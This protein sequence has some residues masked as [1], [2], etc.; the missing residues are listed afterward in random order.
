MQGDVK[1][2]L[3]KLAIISISLSIILSKYFQNSLFKFFNEDIKVALCT[4]GKKE[5]LYA[6][7]FIEYYI[8]LGIDHIFIYD[9]NKNNTERISDCIK[10]KYKKKVTV[11]ENIQNYIKKQ[12]DAFTNCYIN[13][14]K[15]FDWFLMVDMDEYLYIVNNTLKR[16]LNSND[17]IKCDFIKF[18]SVIP[19]D[20]NLTNYDNRSLFERFK[21]PYLKQLDVKTIIKGNISKL[22][23]SIH[24]PYSSPERNITC[25]NVGER[26]VVKNNVSNI[27][28][29]IINPI[30]TDKAFIIHFKYKST[31]E[32]IDKYKRGYNNWFF[33]HKNYLFTKLEGFFDTNQITYEKINY[34]ERELH[35]NLTFFKDN[36]NNIYNSYMKKIK[37]NSLNITIFSH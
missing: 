10:N 30:N 6:E 29:G 2:I 25:N 1:Y 12:S 32:F 9:D 28:F 23:Y 36:F 16:Y 11:Y 13:N 19:S 3:S 34:I 31:E 37:S 4:M 5:N 27:D 17:F 22:K 33:K 8:N 24:S 35:L 18:H 20:N 15:R 21:G 7:Q 26:I 14:F